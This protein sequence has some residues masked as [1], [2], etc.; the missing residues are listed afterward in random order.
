MKKPRTV[1]LPFGVLG[2]KNLASHPLQDRIDLIEDNLLQI[3]KDQRKKER[4]N[5][6]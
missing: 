2:E 5:P 4:S 6:N 1:L 3:R